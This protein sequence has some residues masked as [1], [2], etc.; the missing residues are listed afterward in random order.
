MRKLF[1]GVAEKLADSESEILQDLILCQ[2]KAMD[3]GG[4][5]HVD[6]AKVDILMKPS[7]TYNAVI[8]SFDQTQPFSKM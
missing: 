6:H 2:G 1:A 8:A 5:Y 7:P 4:Y 3:L